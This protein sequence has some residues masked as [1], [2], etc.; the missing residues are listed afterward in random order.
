MTIKKKTC[1]ASMPKSANSKS[2]VEVVFRMLT[3]DKEAA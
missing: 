2:C 3:I 1:N